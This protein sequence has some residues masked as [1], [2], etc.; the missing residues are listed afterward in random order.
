MIWYD[1]PNGEWISLD[2]NY[3][4]VIIGYMC[5]TLEKEYISYLGLLIAKLPSYDFLE[6]TFGD[7]SLPWTD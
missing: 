2:L 7:T 6:L 5:N 1:H 4:D 3:D